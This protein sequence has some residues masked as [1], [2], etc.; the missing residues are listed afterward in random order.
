[1]N[2][3]EKI[4]EGDIIFAH[5]YGLL[6]FLIRR[7]TNS[8]Y[9]HCCLYIGRGHLLDS[10]LWGLRY[11]A[12]MAYKDI[13]HKICRVKRATKKQIKEACQHARKI[14]NSKYSIR[15]LFRLKDKKENYTCSQAINECYMIA[16]LILSKR[17]AMCTPGDI[18]KNRRVVIR[19]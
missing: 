9:N 4:K 12:I 19:K 11:R 15:R 13:P 17:G 8:K 18:E 2:D 3:L 14:I 16:G 1:M 6:G 5:N 7:I 10:D